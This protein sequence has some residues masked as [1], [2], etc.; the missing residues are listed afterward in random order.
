MLKEEGRK[1]GCKYVFVDTFDFQA[2]GFYKK[3]GYHEAFVLHEHPHTG[4]RYYFTKEL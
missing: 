1:R 2:P 4:A 3:L